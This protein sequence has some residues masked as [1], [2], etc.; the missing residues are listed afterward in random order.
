MFDG[1]PKIR[2]LAIKLDFEPFY[3]ILYKN[4]SSSTH[5]SSVINGVVTGDENGIAQI[6]QIRLPFDSES[7]TGLCINLSVLLF[8]KFIK[9]KHPERQNDFKNW[10]LN[11][12]VETKIL[13]ERKL[14]L[15]K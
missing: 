9:A 8:S 5:G 10:Y 2:D 13:L 12:R 6:N 7:V 1:P 15:K 4:W 11:F 3:E 14:F